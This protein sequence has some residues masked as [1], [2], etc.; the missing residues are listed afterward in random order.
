MLQSSKYKS[1]VDR[2]LESSQKLKRQ[3]PRIIVVSKTR[4]AEE[5]K[6]V[7]DTGCRDFGE[8]YVEEMVEKS[9]QVEASPTVV[10]PGYTLALHRTPSEQQNQESAN[11]QSLHVALSR[12]CEVL[13]RVM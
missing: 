4:T 5:I 2:V 9:Q 10:A 13:S 7:Y 6:A 11:S 3:V 8:N 1:L 12:P